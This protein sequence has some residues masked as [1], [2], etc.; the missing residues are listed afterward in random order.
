MAVSLFEHA[1]DAFPHLQVI[2]HELAEIGS[3]QESGFATRSGQP[4]FCIVLL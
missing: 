2:A 3:G 1:V 4:F